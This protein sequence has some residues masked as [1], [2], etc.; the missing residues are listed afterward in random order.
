MDLNA[1]TGAHD[2]FVNLFGHRCFYGRFV[3]TYLLGT[4]FPRVCAM[5]LVKQTTVFGKTFP[6]V[7]AVGQ[8]PQLVDTIKPTFP[9]VDAV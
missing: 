8:T 4:R 7:G 9:M 2:I 5:G 3:W 6:M 1:F